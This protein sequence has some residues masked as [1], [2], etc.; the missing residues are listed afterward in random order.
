MKHEHFLNTAILRIPRFCK[1]LIDFPLEVLLN[2]PDFNDAIFLASEAVYS[3]IGR[4][5]SNTARFSEKLKL[6]LKK[7]HRRMCF[8]P[9][10]FG[11]FASISSLEWGADRI[12][13]GIEIDCRSFYTHTVRQFAKTKNKPAWYVNPSIYRFGDHYRLYEGVNEEGGVRNFNL[14]EIGSEAI[15]PGLLAL[16]GKYYQSALTKLFS[17]LGLSSEATQSCLDQLIENQILLT[18]DQS[19]WLWVKSLP[20]TGRD[21]K[22]SD[23]NTCTVNRVTGVLD[24]SIQKKLRDGIYC[25]DKL[26]RCKEESNLDRFRQRFTEIFD[27]R[28]VPLLLALDPEAGIDYGENA[29]WLMS[30]DHT[31]ELKV[32][33]V[34]RWSEVQEL[35]LRKWTTGRAVETPVIRIEKADLLVLNNKQESKPALSRAV[36]FNVV[37]DQVHIQSAGGSSA[38]AIIGRFTFFDD[39]ILAIAREIS[40]LEQE[41]NQE[42]I[43]AELIHNGDEKTD[44]LNERG[45]FRDYV[46]PVLTDSAVKGSFRIELNDLFLSVR[47]GQLILRSKSL[48]KRIIPRLST[49]FNFHRSPLSIF[50]FLCDLQ[51]E[52]I[53]TGAEFNMSKLFPNLTFYPR[54]C[55]GN[56]ILEKASWHLD[57]QVFAGMQANPETFYE[58]F[59]KYADKLGLPA[60][61][62]NEQSDQRLLIRK[63]NRDDVWM[64]IQT[65]KASSVIILREYLSE[66]RPLVIGQHHE[67]YA[68]ELIAFLVNTKTVYKSFPAISDVPR[69]EVSRYYPLNDWH[70]LKVY[71]HPSGMNGFLTSTLLKFLNTCFKG[72][73][74]QNWYFVR[75]NDGADHL[76][77]RFKTANDKDP[78]FIEKLQAFLPR[79][80]KSAYIRDVQLCTYERELER[81]WPIGIVNAEL[82]FTLSSNLA[83]SIIK[84]TGKMTAGHGEATADPEM[85]LHNELLMQAILHMMSVL[86][87]GELPEPLILSL[88]E[89]SYKGLFQRLQVSKE[90]KIAYDQ[91]YRQLKTSLD[92]LFHA[93][94]KSISKLYLNQ[95]DRHI[96]AVKLE[97][98]AVLLADLIH[99]HINRLCAG[100]Q[101]LIEAE[102]YYYLY[103]IFLQRKFK[104]V[105]FLNP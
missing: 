103:K 94:Q 95:L 1:E 73:L 21:Q 33:K 88:A 24:K 52:G 104:A 96:K 46:I 71:M 11:G 8:R 47:K 25:L 40:Q 70:F 5:G 93:N 37:D 62:T 9:T 87:V 64:L 100:R 10:P 55:Y 91:S 42:V 12:N 83:L 84:Q 48:Q 57:S 60:M 74:L 99:M 50:R 4:H 23:L 51:S 16:T 39:D 66:E 92:V 32:N 18:V 6:T 13:E 53:D 35:L 20:P 65:V 82:L 28:E 27:Q 68:H 97:M 77:I 85:T 30:H 44:K 36:L 54:V 75:Y 7:Y 69:E 76:R 19:S 45:H 41:A 3:E 102:C 15:P 90:Q 29:S 61:F 79:L 78:L 59:L 26:T 31:A 58:S 81:Y 72:G 89:D 101:L 2:D 63:D 67:A 17:P 22:S 49:S 98:R 38:A 14:S 56:V 105:H 43:F 86:R 80:Q 34:P